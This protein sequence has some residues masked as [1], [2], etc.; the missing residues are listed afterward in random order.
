[1]RKNDIINYLELKKNELY[2]KYGVTTLGLYGSYA[3]DEAT[4]NSDIDIFYERDKSFELKS[5][6]EF[7]NI[8][9]KLANE[10]NVK[11]VDFVS[12]E[13]MNPIIKY[14]AKKDFIYV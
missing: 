7:L 5:G 11:K 6:L 1:M 14:Y 2:K 10:L 4:Q 12:L 13:S 3:R 8:S 9:E